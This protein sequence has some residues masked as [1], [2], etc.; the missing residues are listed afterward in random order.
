MVGYGL[1]AS[2][3]TAKWLKPVV[4]R[5][6][7]GTTEGVDIRDPTRGPSASGV[8]TTAMGSSEQMHRTSTMRGYRP[9]VSNVCPHCLPSPWRIAAGLFS[10]LPQLFNPHPARPLGVL[11]SDILASPAAHCHTDNTI[12]YFHKSSFNL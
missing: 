12:V 10:T 9:A 5:E 8:G 1:Y 4:R 3:L 11:P 2:P 7:R 6:S